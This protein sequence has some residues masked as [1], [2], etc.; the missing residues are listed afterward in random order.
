MGR[1]ARELEHSHALCVLL[2][3]LLLCGQPNWPFLICFFLL[4]HVVVEVPF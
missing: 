2:L 4:H 3:L 1:V